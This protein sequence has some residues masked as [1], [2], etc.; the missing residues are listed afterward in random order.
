MNL[1]RQSLV[2]VLTTQ[3]KQE[4]IHYKKRKKLAIG[5][6]NTKTLHTACI[7]TVVVA[8]GIRDAGAPAALVLVPVLFPVDVSR[9]P[10]LY[11]SSQLAPSLSQGV[12]SPA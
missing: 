9:A 11:V 10:A 4:K 3:N 1:S 5:K 2:L 8:G 7:V 6:K 12:S